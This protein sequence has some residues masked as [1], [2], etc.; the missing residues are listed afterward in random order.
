VKQKK[1]LAVLVVLLLIAGGIWYFYFVHDKPVVTADASAATQSYQLLSVDNPQLHTDK[2]KRARETEYRSTG[3]NIF[4]A[5]PAPQAVSPDPRPKPNDP[6]HPIGPVV[7]LSPPTPTVAPLPVKFFGYGTVPNG[8]VR[9]AFFTDG[10]ES[11]VVS[12]GEVL[13]NRFRILK[14]GNANL[15]YEEISTGLRGTAPLEDQGEPPSAQ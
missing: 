4:S 10:A 1:Q 2:Q 5:I 13:L 3:R 9:R 14:I 6:S 8:T 12:E 15:E 11:Y 7:P